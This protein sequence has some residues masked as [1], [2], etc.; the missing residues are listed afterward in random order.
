MP[1]IYV[2]VDTCVMADIVKTLD[3]SN[4]LNPI[5]GKFLSHKMIP[6][7][8]SIKNDERFS[9]IITSTFTFVELINKFSSI[10]EGTSVTIGKLYSL[11]KQPPEWLIIEPL[12]EMTEKSFCEVPIVVDG[13]SV[14]MDDAIHV[15]TAI[16]RKDDVFFLTSD[17]ILRK[18][19]IPNLK[20]I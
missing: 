14:S 3:A 8:N 5:E 9:K 7:L 4:E 17:H 19:K 12:N 2:Y 20:F 10:F 11:M 15:A 16:Q 6:I 1:S 18:I 13:E